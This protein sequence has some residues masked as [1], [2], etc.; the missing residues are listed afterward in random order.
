MSENKAKSRRPLGWLFKGADAEGAD[1][2]PAVPKA[3]APK[4]EAEPAP[5]APPPPDVPPPSAASERRGSW[6]SRLAAGLAKTSSRLSGGLAGL[7]TKRKLDAATLEEL[8]D[9]LVEADLGLETAARVAD[10]LRK[11]RYETDVSAADVR[12]VLTGEI[13][14]VLAPVARPLA[15]P[16]GVRPHVVLFVGV[17]GAGKTTTIGKLAAKFA[18][19]GKKTLIAAG[20]TFRAA[21]IDQLKVWGGRAGVE[22]MASGTGADAAGLAFDAL[23]RARAEG[24]DVLLIDTAGRLQNKAGLMSELAKITRV[25]RKLDEQAPHDVLL[26]LDATTGQNALA[27]VEVFRDKAGVTGLVMTK[28]DGTAKGGI[29][30]AIAAKFGLPIHAIGVGESLDDL[31]PF[32]AG[33]FARALVSL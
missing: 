6:L 16:S 30:V 24:F 10:A 17:N 32:E 25:L 13:A 9:L 18:G 3:A 14:R 19:E 15:A 22:V 21:A 33:A 1:A 8:E 12:E 26:V 5:D 11:G 4:A 23:K 7:L 28:L 2:S 20:D 27:Q 31:E 29:L